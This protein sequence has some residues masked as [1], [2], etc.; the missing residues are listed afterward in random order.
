[1]ES[2]GP[3]TCKLLACSSDATLRLRH[4][5]GFGW[6]GAI[7]FKLFACS[8]DATLQLRHG[9]GFW[10][11]CGKSVQVTCML[12]WCYATATSWLGVSMEWGGAKAFKLLARSSDAM[13]R[14]RHSFGFGWGGA[15]TFKVLARW[16]D[17]ML[18]LRH[19]FGFG[20]GGVG[21]KRASYLHAQVML[22]YGYGVVW[23]FDGVGWGKNVQVTCMLKWCYATATSW[24]WVWVGWGEAM[25]FKLLACSSD[26]TLR[27]RNGFGFGLAGVRQWRSSYLHAQAMIRY[28]FVMALGLGWQG[29]GNDVQVTCMLKW[30]YAT[31]TSKFPRVPCQA[32]GAPAKM[33]LLIL[34]C[35][36]EIEFGNGDATMEIPRTTWVLPITS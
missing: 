16:N 1:M 10:V 13:L 29:W 5:F 15:I 26:A 34:S 14:L 12:K 27:L 25:T 19:G 32:L 35:F 3:K 24:L 17:A 9:L 18:R 20:W 23:G 30:W 22:S 6:G 31:A 36:K 11:G 2:G 21:Q 33:G 28:G 4:G 7:T 8:S